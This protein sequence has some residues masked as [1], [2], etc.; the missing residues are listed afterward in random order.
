MNTVESLIHAAGFDCF[1]IQKIHS[2]KTINHFTDWLSQD[3][4][5]DMEWL[6][7][8][9]AVEKRNDP[10]QIL[11]N[12]KTYISLIYQYTP[13]RIPEH[14]LR[15]PSRGIIARYALYDDYHEVIKKK[16]HTLAAQLQ[17]EF[18]ECEW[19]AYVDTG[20][21]L[22]REWAAAVKCG[23]IGKN[24]NLI[25]PTLGSFIYIAELLLSSDLPVVQ[26]ELSVRACGPCVQCIDDCPT[27]ALYKEKTIDAR[28]CISYLTIEHKDSI[29]EELRPLMKNRIFGCDICQEN[30]PW[31]KN[32]PAQSKD[33]FLVHEERIAPPLSE[34]LFFT[35]QEFR[36]RFRRSPV[37]RARRDGFMR[38]VAIALGNWGSAEAQQVL[39]QMQKNDPSELV[40]EH[41]HW[42]LKQCV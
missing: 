38:N 27:C 18:G 16:L 30:C 14:L 17:D 34:L 11:P 40:Q 33:D 3:H 1:G 23:F 22:E 13:P 29:P 26:Q 2:S 41:V 42:A 35:D 4:H 19:K 9:H 5:A 24:T 25:H 6:S 20:P 7:R 21:I 28:R 15:D 36:T 8:E 32:A 12:A 39:K 31:N 10:F 37:L